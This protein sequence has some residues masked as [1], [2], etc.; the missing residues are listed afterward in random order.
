MHFPDEPLNGQD[1]LYLSLPG[2]MARAA[3]TSRFRPGGGVSR[4]VYDLVLAQCRLVDADEY[5]TRY[6]PIILFL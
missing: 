1:A 4:Y 6:H 3:A 5:L 2:D